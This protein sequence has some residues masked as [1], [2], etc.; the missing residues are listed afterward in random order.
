LSRFDTPAVEPVPGLQLS[1]NE[2][3]LLEDNF[4]AG[5]GSQVA[6][7]VALAFLEK[8]PAGEAGEGAQTV[9]ELYRS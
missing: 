9:Y 7:V 5:Q 3:P 2:E 6:L 1:H 8:V 4:P